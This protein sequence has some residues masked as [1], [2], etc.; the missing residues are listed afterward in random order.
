MDLATARTQI[1]FK[2]MDLKRLFKKRL[3]R[4]RAEYRD[5]RY[6]QL[7]DQAKENQQGGLTEQ[8][9]AREKLP[10]WSQ[11]SEEVFQEGENGQLFNMLPRGQVR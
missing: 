7:H 3:V 8:S 2:A 4:K 11:R 1:A 10:V 9:E 5:L 6:L